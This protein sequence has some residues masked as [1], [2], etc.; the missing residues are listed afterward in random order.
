MFQECTCGPKYSV[1]ES[2]G[3][4]TGPIETAKNA[5]NMGFLRMARPRHRLPRTRVW[6]G[7]VELGGSGSPFVSSGSP[8]VNSVDGRSHLTTLY[9]FDLT[10][11]AF[12]QAALVQGT[13]GDFYGTTDWGGAG[14]NCGPPPAPAVGR[15]SAC[16]WASV[17]LWKRRPPPAKS[18]QPSRSWEAT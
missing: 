13:N 4:L 2:C 6:G 12:P 7:N 1:T 9:S 10:D 18:A 11:G 17:R 5:H 15:S 14:S 3:W 16:L 8:L